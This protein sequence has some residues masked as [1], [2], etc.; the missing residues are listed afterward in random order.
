MAHLKNVRLGAKIQHFC[1]HAGIRIKLEICVDNVFLNVIITS[2]SVLLGNGGHLGCHLEFF[3][4]L[5][6]DQS[7]PG[8]F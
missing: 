1:Y 8:V 4:M 3:R 2:M 7:S 6:G 5:N